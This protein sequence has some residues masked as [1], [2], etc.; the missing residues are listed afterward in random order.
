[1][2]LAFVFWR[3]VVF[4]NLGEISALRSLTGFNFHHYHYGIFFVFIACLFFIFHGV[5]R[6]SI[7]LA[8]FGFGS[9][10]DGSVSRI[11][12]NSIRPIEIVR[13]NQAFGLTIFLFAVLVLLS[14]DFYLIF[15]KRRL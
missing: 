15:E 2:I 7:A 4:V 8:G 5:D 11:L 14:V 10:F 9:F 1:M 3:F 6:Y 13:Y 12:G